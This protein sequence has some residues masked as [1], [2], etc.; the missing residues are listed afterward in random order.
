VRTARTWL[1]AGADRVRVAARW[2]TAPQRARADVRA[3]RQLVRRLR[4]NGAGLPAAQLAAAAARVAELRRDAVAR[5]LYDAAVRASD[6]A[7]DILLARRRLRGYTGEVAPAV[8]ER[9]AEAAFGPSSR[10]RGAVTAI[11]AV[12]P[13]RAIGGNVEAVVRHHFGDGRTLI[14]KTFRGTAPREVLVYRS[15]LLD[16]G[17]CWWRA[18]RPYLAEEEGTGR[19]HLFLEDLG[20]THWSCS[21]TALAAASRALGEMNGRWLADR[22]LIERWPWG[23]ETPRRLGRFV[24]PQRRQLTGVLDDELAGRVLRTLAALAERE[25]ELVQ[26]H[27]GLPTTFCHGD[28]VPSN[29]LVGEG[30]VV[31]FDWSVSGLGAVG[32]DVGSLLSIPGPGVSDEVVGRCLRAY[33]EGIGAKDRASADEIELGYRLWFVSRSL[34]RQ[35]AHLPPASPR[36]IGSTHRRPC[37]VGVVGSAPVAGARQPDP[38]LRRGARAARAHALT[39]LR[40]RRTSCR[41][42]RSAGSSSMH[43]R[44]SWAKGVGRSPSRTATH[45]PPTYPK[46]LQRCTRPSV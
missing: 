24:R 2:L 25:V 19:W 20:R 9:A 35:L 23:S 36:R 22:S 28:A 21:P 39:A 15:G 40:A 8:I 37:G 17:G 38:R 29:L 32:T 1:A 16:A 4:T 31:L 33:R 10:R 45:P 3:G 13:G 30:R 43:A 18:P 11:R 44:T 12:Q 42:G 5:E 6:G 34:R 46:H 41:F 7:D 26:A 27:A 14:R